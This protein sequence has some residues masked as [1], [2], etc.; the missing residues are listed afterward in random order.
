[1]IAVQMYKNTI[2]RSAL[3]ETLNYSTINRY[4]AVGVIAHMDLVMVTTNMSDL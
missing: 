4:S 3:L 2:N 1:M